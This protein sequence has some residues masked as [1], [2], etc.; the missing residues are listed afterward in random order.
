MIS[1]LI[2]LDILEQAETLKKPI[3]WFY[4]VDS[5]PELRDDKQS[6][7]NG[8]LNRNL[9]KFLYSYG[10]YWVPP[11]ECSCP[12]GSEYV[13]QRGVESRQ[14]RV[15]AARSWPLFREKKNHLRRCSK[16]L[17]GHN[18]DFRAKFLT[19]IKIFS[20]EDFALRSKLWPNNFS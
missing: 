15:T 2:Y 18:F 12:D 5:A 3:R 9:L 17:G 11:G 16:K 4:N 13:W 8:S 10:I 19:Y 7:K 1:I 6:P 14:G 20:Q